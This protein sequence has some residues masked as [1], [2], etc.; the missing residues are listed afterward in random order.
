MDKLSLD[1]I[2]AN[3]IV[4]CANARL[5]Q[6][7][8]EVHDRKKKAQGE[9]VWPYLQAVTMTQY[10]LAMAQQG[11]LS[12]DIVASGY[13]WPLSPIQEHLIW[14]Q[15]ISADLDTLEDGALWDVD[16]LA[17]I[18]QDAQAIL[19]RSL[20]PLTG[21]GQT[22]EQ[23]AFL[24]WRTLW[25]KR[26]EQA[27]CLD[28]YRYRLW[29][30][31]QLNAGYG[32]VPQQ[33]ILA[34]FIHFSPDEERLV[35]VLRSRGVH[36]ALLDTDAI[37][38][39]AIHTRCYSSERRQ[40]RAVAHWA[41]DFMR[42]APQARLAIIA[43]DLASVRNT[44]WRAL[45]KALHPENSAPVRPPQTPCFEFSLG[46]PLTREPM[47]SAALRFL[48]LIDSAGETNILEWGALLRLPWWGRES[49][50]DAAHRL[51]FRLR[52]LL[53][54]KASWRLLC[55]VL[56]HESGAMA[57]PLCQAY[58][59]MADRMSL[60]QTQRPSAWTQEFMGLL[61][62][63]QWPGS[64]ALSSALWQARCAFDEV[65]DGLET[66]D[67][68]V[69]SIA[70]RDAVAHLHRQCALRIFQPETDP[71]QNR[72]QVLGPLEALAE[73]VDAL[74]VLDL[75]ENSWPPPARPNPMLPLALQRKMPIAHASADIQR[76]FARKV[77]ARWLRSA[78]EVIFS[79]AKARAGK[80]QMPSGLIEAFWGGTEQAADVLVPQLDH[81]LSAD[82]TN[83]MEAVADERAPAMSIGEHLS[84]GTS[85]LRAQA[86]C[87]A[88]GYFRYRL[89]AQPLPEPRQ[90]LDAAMRG[91]LLHR[92]MELFWSG[93]DS[94]PKVLLQDDNASA[95]SERIKACVEGALRDAAV[96]MRGQSAP[97]L[98]DL[99]R[100]RLEDLLHEW[101]E[102]EKQRRDDFHIAACELEKTIEI[103]DI[104]IRVIIDRMDVIDDARSKGLLLDYKTS[105]STSLS[106]WFQKRIS[107]PQLPL[108]AAFLG[109]E[110]AGVA[111]ARVR[112]GECA[113]SG[114]C[115]Q[116]LGIPGVVPIGEWKKQQTKLPANVSDWQ[117]LLHYWRCGIEA[118]ATE[119]QEG[120]AAVIFE[121]ESDLQ[122]CEVKPLLRLAEIEQ[123]KNLRVA[124]EGAPEK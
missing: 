121:K 14:A 88:W 118:L 64:R 59:Q 106:P 36:V 11:L 123:Q 98:M 69:G 87:P 80:T 25:D 43:P 51:D 112:S 116:D 111:F 75:D 113:F 101:L 65:M 42:R 114:V 102:R 120:H 76:E 67:S 54:E 73:P 86:L 99:E 56:K 18:A 89:R 6:H 50:S 74:W 55:D 9:Q 30:I 4:L 38:P 21:G 115:A 29:A 77:Q 117:G 1:H 109:Q 19:T 16:A 91:A 35:D 90:G 40:Y 93:V 44:L 79:Y 122:W 63:A 82:D 53:P 24:R 97:R 12:G 7:L 17:Q 92:A 70:Y 105:A 110:I 10:L 27:C 13:R 3:A 2:G 68:L 72:I 78:P 62:L 83:R 84:G 124:W 28:V 20:L 119:I 32:Q 95:C 5:A 47:I 61:N 48:A 23:R 41:A 34:G 22:D 103:S 15:T 107:Q 100:Q 96:H 81:E 85:A 66:L 60:Q 46:L 104:E 52:Q 58:V 45:E 57:L 33:V 49:D 108:Y 94:S 8:R 37:E 31:D 26:L 71:G 39:A